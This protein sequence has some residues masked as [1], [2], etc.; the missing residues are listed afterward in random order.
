MK[1]GFLISN[2]CLISLVSSS[3][4]S[5]SIR[6]L[7]L[8]LFTISNAV[9]QQQVFI[10]EKNDFH[11]STVLH[12]ITPPLSEND[13]YG[14]YHFRKS[15]TLQ[16]VPQSFVIHV[17]ADNRYRLYVNG[18]NVC[19]GPARGDLNNWQFESVE[20]ASLLHAC[21]NT[22][23]AVVWNAGL[24]K[25]WAQISLQTAFILRGVADGKAV[26]NTDDTWKVIKNKA[27]TFFKDDTIDQFP[28]GVGPGELIDGKQYP[29][30]WQN[31]KFDDS[32][33]ASVE[34]I[35]KANPSSSF[36]QL[37]PRTIPFMR[38]EEHRFA[39]VRRTTD[40]EISNDFVHG[41]TP[42]IIP[43]N[44]KAEILLDQGHLTIAYPEL[45]ISGGSGA[46]ITL[47]YNEA[48][49]DANGR[50]SH[51]D[52][53]SHMF[54]KGLYDIM[55]PDGRSHRTY[56]PLWYRT[57]RY[58]Q[59]SIETGDE[60]LTIHDLKCM[61]T[62]YPFKQVAKFQSNDSTL[63]D[64]WDVSWRTAL[65]CAH[66]TYMDCPYYEQLQY[67]GDTRIQMLVSLAVT[68]DDRLMRQAIDQFYQ[69]RVESG[70][71]LCAYPSNEN[72]K[73]PT[74]SLI[75][76]LMIHDHWMWK[77]D[78][79]L[80]KKYQKGIEGVL[81]WFEQ[82]LQGGLLTNL[83]DDSWDRSKNWQFEHWHYVD[84]T[85]GFPIGVP[86]GV[87][88]G[89]PASVTLLYVYALQHAAILMK[90][91]SQ[92]DLATTYH[93]LAENIKR[94][95]YK[96]C[97]NSERLLLADTPEQ[98]HFSQHTNALAV[99]V[100]LVYPENQK[101]IIECILEDSTLVQCSLYFSFY[102]HRAMVK[103]GLGNRYLERMA[104]W[105]EM[106]TLGF[107][108]FPEHPFVN[109]RSD[110]HAWSAHPMVDF[111]VTIGGISP[112]APG[113]SK[114]RIEPFLNGLK[115]VFVTMP[116]PEGKIVCEYKT[117]NNKTNARVVLP[118]QITG[119]FFWN[120]LVI[121][122]DPGENTLKDL[123]ALSSQR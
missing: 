76:I 81:R 62:G 35:T 67:G 85:P 77:G 101:R 80:V 63:Q 7:L 6:I 120:N 107:T 108:T 23:A 45:E 91:L 47:T 21:D 49:F 79:E 105:K 88:C 70:L 58:V 74:F 1:R 100:D 46:R 68:G 89:Q 32:G 50:K 64:I 29:W 112:A 24:L 83:P 55:V 95:V 61:A 18:V 9:A 42:L 59:V 82:Y 48:L 33:W 36:W 78:T 90:E 66:E 57:F 72:K 52:S 11:P 13:E 5:T 10:G 60:P 110:C 38:E 121:P 4:K 115:E 102:L 93:R 104:K 28:D 99:L 94:N 98:K 27:I 117:C 15:F 26:L 39:T 51:R 37:K 14:V 41:D 53:V 12:W 54:L 3:G 22:V 2:C 103:A 86:P 97:W 119:E 96:K 123:Q 113:F 92:K 30:G 122:L 31:I 56:R 84:D 71:T 118:D 16:N 44:H 65:C 106:L 34:V 116:H 109:T 75:W 43:P 111:L 19:H 8:F 40:I 25:P 17:S 20:V 114:V 69:S 73:I 87:Y